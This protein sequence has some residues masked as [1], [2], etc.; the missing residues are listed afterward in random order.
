MIRIDAYYIFQMGARIHPI[1][2]LRAV[3]SALGPATTFEDARF[4]TYIA[5]AALDELLHRT[6]FGLRT[7]LQ[8]GET[9]LAAIR[10]LKTAIDEAQAAGNASDIIGWAHLYAVTSGLTAF[11]AVLGAEISLWPL[12][13][14]TRKAGFDTA[15]LIEQGNACFPTDLAIKVPSAIPDI[16]EGTRCIAYESFTAGAF[17]LHRANE[18]VLRAYWDVVS[19]GAPQPASRNMGEYLREMDTRNIG[20]SRVKA[21]LKDLKDLHR[22]PLIHPEHSISNADDAIALMNGVHTVIFHLLQGI[23]APVSP[24]TLAGGVAATP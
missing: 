22:N 7:S 23:P 21:A 13:L 3:A 18:S 1:G 10:E 5:E 9:L 4:P 16:K 17:H 11:E 19:H 20:D 14:A 24:P 15:I 2:D 8:S 6:V 12:Y